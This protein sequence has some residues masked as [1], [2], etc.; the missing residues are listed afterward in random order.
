MAPTSML[1]VVPRPAIPRSTHLPHSSKAPANVGGRVNHRCRGTVPTLTSSYSSFSTFA[2][3]KDLLLLLSL[4][5][6]LTPESRHG[7]LWTVPRAALQSQAVEPPYNVVITGSTKGLGLALAKEFL[8][9]GDR[10]VISS[11]SGDRVKGVTKELEALHGHDKVKGIECNVG[12]PEDVARL[13]SFAQEQL[14]EVHMWIN[15]AGS[16]AYRY[17]PLIEAEDC[18][19][20]EIVETNTLGVMLSCRYAIR[21]MRQQP[22]GGH[23]FNMD[24]AGADGNAT[25][26]F[27]AYGATKRSL[28]QF[29]KS[30]QA[31]LQMLDVKNVIVHNLSPGMVTTELLMSGSDTRQAKFFINALAEP[32]EEVASYLVP[33]LRAIPASGAKKS[34][35]IRFLTGPKAYVQILGRLLFKLRKNRYVAEE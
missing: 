12:V 34:T 35:Y 27:A 3:Q 7:Q 4:R 16:N 14:G 13:A 28:A 10:V 2:R 25:P 11:R 15:N 31:E 9:S 19:L 32:A 22:H 21:M 29:T 18:A 30:L 23:I 33:R 1:H 26:R 20:A 5:G 17:G 24:G 6:T 8:R